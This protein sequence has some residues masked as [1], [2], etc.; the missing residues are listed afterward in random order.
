MNSVVS[1]TQARQRWAET[2]EQALRGPVEITSHGRTVAVVMDPI[3][4][5]RA[6][7]ALEDVADIAAADAALN[8]VLA[9]APAAS[10]AEVAAELG[11]DLGAQRSVDQGA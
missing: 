10:L 7:E 4:A 3:L 1:A 8:E 5:R 11:I 6:L 2:L 9:G